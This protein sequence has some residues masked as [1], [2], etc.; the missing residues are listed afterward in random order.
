[1]RGLA[2]GFPLCFAYPFQAFVRISPNPRV[3]PSPLSGDAAMKQVETWLTLP[4]VWTPGPTERHLEVLGQLIR[5]SRA[6]GNLV[7]D[8]ELAAL[9][10]QHGLELISTDG[11]FGRFSNL[12]WRNPLA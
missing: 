4:N 2:L 3:F 12:R 9:A 11:D 10:I 8:A 1:M 5:E 7:S 6:V